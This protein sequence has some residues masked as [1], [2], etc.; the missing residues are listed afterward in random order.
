[1]MMRKPRPEQSKVQRIIGPPKRL[2]AGGK[3]QR[4]L[5]A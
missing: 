5:C 2:T 1:V 4:P 3:E